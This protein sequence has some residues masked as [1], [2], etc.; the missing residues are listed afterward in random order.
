MPKCLTVSLKQK[1]AMQVSRVSIGKKKLVYVIVA[2]KSLKYP[3]GRSRV[4]YIG[5]TKKGMARIAQSAAARAKQVLSLRGVREFHVR[6]LTCAPRSNVRTWAVLERAL[7]LC[8][9]NRYGRLPLCN[10]MGQNTQSHGAFD[11]FNKDRLE[12]LLE[13]LA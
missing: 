9:R 12:S 5:T 2:S 7:L 1:Q 6:I 3:W 4:A 11:Y 10:K 8:F 13:T